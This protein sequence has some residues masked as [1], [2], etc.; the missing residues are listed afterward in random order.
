MKTINKAIFALL[1]SLPS[2]GQLPTFD[3]SNFITNVKNWGQGIQNGATATQTLQNGM[4]LLSQAT[5][6]YGIA[7]QEVSYIKNKQILL[8]VGFLAQH[9][10]IEGQPG[11][12][13][14]LSAASG[15]AYA[16]QQWQKMLAPGASLQSRIAMANSF[17][18]DA[19]NSIGSCNQAAAGNAGSLAS[20]EQM[21]VDLNPAANTRA[22]QANI[23]NMSQTQQLRVAQCQQNVQLQQAKMQLLEVQERQQRDQAMLTQRANTAIIANQLTTTDTAAALNGLVD[24]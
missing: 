9:A 11:F 24:R 5:Q 18:A 6:M 14:A 17:A 22:N 16:G 3:A 8:A 20:L 13:K 21:S 19:L 2:F 10:M 4:K 7:S 15:I 12:D 1:F 23:S